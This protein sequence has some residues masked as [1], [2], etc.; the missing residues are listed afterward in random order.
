[1]AD[2]DHVFCRPSTPVANFCRGVNATAWRTPAAF[3]RTDSYFD[4]RNKADYLGGMKRLLVW[5]CLYP[6]EEPDSI[7]PADSLFYFP[8]LPRL[9]RLFPWCGRR[10]CSL[11]FKNAF[12]P[13]VSGSSL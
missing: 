3:A 2:D 5:V 12:A 6:Q 1:V 7:H 13:N 10:H 8:C 11:V 9:R 4:T